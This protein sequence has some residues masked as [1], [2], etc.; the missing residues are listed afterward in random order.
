MQLDYHRQEAESGRRLQK[1]NQKTFDGENSKKKAI[2]AA[3]MMIEH[4]NADT[5]RG[6]VTQRGFVP[7]EELIFIPRNLMIFD[8]MGRDTKIGQKVHR[9]WLGKEIS[10][11]SEKVTQIVLYILQSL[12]DKRHFFRPY[13]SILPS[14]F[15]TLPIF[16]TQEEISHLKGSKIVEEINER[17][18]RL[19]IDY[20]SILSVAPEFESFAS[21]EEFLWARS[22][23][24]SRNFG[25][26]MDNQKKS[27][28]VPFA[29][30]L[31]HAKPKQTQWHYDESRRGFSV[32]ALHG[33]TRSLSDSGNNSVGGGGLPRLPY[34]SKPSSTHH[35]TKGGMNTGMRKTGV[36]RTKS[37]ITSSSSSKDHF[38]TGKL[39]IN[40]DDHSTLSA[41]EF[42]RR[43]T[44]SY[45]HYYLRQR[46][47]KEV[48]GDQEEEKSQ[49][50]G[51]KT[52]N[53]KK[54]YHDTNLLLEGGEEGEEEMSHTETILQS[55]L[56][57]LRELANVCEERLS[58]YSTIEIEDILDQEEGRERKGCG[59]SKGGF[60]FGSDSNGSLSPPLSLTPSEPSPFLNGASSELHHPNHHEGEQQPQHASKTINQKHAMNLVNGEKEILFFW[61][62][63]YEVA[64]HIFPILF[65]R[66]DEMRG[67]KNGRLPSSSSQQQKTTCSSVEKTRNEKTRALSVSSGIAH[68][69]MN[70]G[71]VRQ[72]IRKIINE[73]DDKLRTTTT[74]SVQKVWRKDMEKYFENMLARYW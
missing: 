13:Y 53:K 35:S 62:K 69:N 38:W 43:K 26:Y 4:K 60:G 23:V 14:K 42:Q 61:I 65:E 74:M 6:V 17:K 49:E 44:R 15:S 67:K 21:F 59:S 27:A 9:A 34:S 11:S 50:E 32:K 71:H 57:T 66:D 36:S 3:E 2:T 1:K 72:L 47:S 41:L 33:I 48:I 52:K 7:S 56:L 58:D 70:T 45:L 31:N 73:N 5:M 30:L 68:A 37:T 19:Q 8:D 40:A 16:W 54:F 24:G 10:L 12:K 39:S 29:D 51:N 63:V 64:T 55:E 28:L 22:A 46:H 25:V 20:R 18:T